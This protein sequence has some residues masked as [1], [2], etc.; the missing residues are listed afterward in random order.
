MILGAI[1]RYSIKVL[2]GEDVI[3][4]GN[5]DDIP[6]ELKKVVVKKVVELNSTLMTIEIEK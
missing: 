6:E 5:A 1:R 3:Y 2:A 4:E